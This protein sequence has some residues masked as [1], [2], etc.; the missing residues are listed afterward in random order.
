M[1]KELY[2]AN[3]KRIAKNTLYLYF[4]MLLIMGVTLYTSRIVL[5]ALGVEDFGIYNVVGGVAS[6]FVFFSSSLSNATQRFLNFELGLGNINSVKN[7]FNI[8]LLVY[9]VIALVVLVASEFIGIW[10]INNKLVIPAN[11]FDSALWVFH[12]M[13]ASLVVTLLGTVFDSVLIAR[14]NMRLYAYIGVWEA[15]GKLL[16]VYIL[17]HVDFD[18]LKLYSGLLLCIT[19]CVKFIPAIFCV[20]KYPECRIRFY[21]NFSL[22]TKLFR[23]VGWN[24]LGTAVWAVN[25][26]GMSILLN[27]FFGPAVNAAKAVA[28]QMNAAINNFGS[29]FFVAVRPQI[30][31]SYAHRDY[32]YFVELIY[33]S[34]RYSFF[35][36]W[37]LCLPFLLKIDCILTLWLGIVPQYA[38]DFA[39]WILIYSL[40]NILTNPFWS[41][42]QAIGVLRRYILVGSTVYLMAFPVSYLFLK[43][44]YNPIVVFQ[45]L[46]GIRFV[47]LFVIVKIV[48]NYV[49]ISIFQYIGK[50]I[51]PI[52]LVVLLSSIIMLAFSYYSSESFASLFLVS[53]VCFIVVLLT[54]YI[55]GI[56]SKE[57]CEIKMKF[58]Q[59]FYNDKEN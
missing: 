51:V 47:Y 53:L 55:V 26:Q 52:S 34:S 50:V 19:V 5:N 15:V 23:F 35:L 16:I 36:M 38:P 20:C 46:S 41:A 8:S 24:G 21:W 37:L 6:S 57:K 59:Y 29:N 4:R 28:T 49:S 13:M 56:T 18:K 9:A 43:C 58:I 7:I 44:G 27:I 48:G 25:E 3:N 54:I 12:A 30:V 42:I 45:V 32:S 1:S 17:D 2:T 14:E 33:N 11:R 40:I 22:F 31:K 39:R 10:L